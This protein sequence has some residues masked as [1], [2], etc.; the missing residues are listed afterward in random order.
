MSDVKLRIYPDPV[1]KR[2]SKPV[3]ELSGELLQ[4]E[5]APRVD[6]MFRIMD[7]E[8]GI[9]L[10]APQAG[11]SVRIFVTQI[12]LGQAE[13]DRRV[14]INP[15]IVS[16][17]GAEEDEEGCLS[18]PDLRGRIVRHREVRLRAVDLQGR[19]FEET[20]YGLAAR[21]WQHEID[22]LDGILFI[23]R[24]SAGDRL[25]IKQGL[26]ELEEKYENRAPSSG[27]RSS[28]T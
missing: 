25:S 23:S 26:R 6:T 5:V 2:R 8:G 15:E 20:G 3:P 13:G 19:S 1:L 16:A 12:P 18:F 4:K 22:H 24:M 11:W 14:Y 27:R 28:L 10:A 9:G 7:E 21:C 17:S